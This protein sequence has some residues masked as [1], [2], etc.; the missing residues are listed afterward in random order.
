MDTCNIYTWHS[1]IHGSLGELSISVVEITKFYDSSHEYGVLIFIRCDNL[2][3]NEEDIVI[4]DKEG[5][6]L[7]FT[8]H[9]SVPMM[10]RVNSWYIGGGGIHTSV[11]KI[12][13]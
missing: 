2:G 13:H 1:Y 6:K 11:R 7:G 10:T 5:K 12:S 3:I 4:D 9:K 8:L